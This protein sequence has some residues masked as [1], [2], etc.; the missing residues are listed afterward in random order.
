[1]TKLSDLGPPIPGERHGGRD[2][3]EH[4]HFYACPSCGQK[5]DQRDLRQVFWHEVVGH[6]PLEPEPEAKVI[7]FPRRK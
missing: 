4:E 1:M 3:P 7:E 6:E 5:V 2:I